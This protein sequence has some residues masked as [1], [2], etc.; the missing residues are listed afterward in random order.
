MKT[1]SNCLYFTKYTKERKMAFSDGAASGG[2][3]VVGGVN[4]IL[5]DAASRC[6]TCL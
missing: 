4:V 5:L 2:E 3:P 1:V 6:R